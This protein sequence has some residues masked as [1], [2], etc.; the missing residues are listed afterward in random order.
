MNA[1][2]ETVTVGQIS[3]F[4]LKIK[5][6]LF[7]LYTRLFLYLILKSLKRATSTVNTAESG[8]AGAEGYNEETP[9]PKW[10]RGK[11]HRRRSVS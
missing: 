8:R 11:G 5:G 2:L 7:F 3:H 4:L 10:E 9:S 1:S 6:S